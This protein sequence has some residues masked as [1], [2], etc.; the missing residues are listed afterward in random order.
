[1]NDI[2]TRLTRDHQELDAILRRL[3]ED[4]TAPE[5]DA[6]LQSTWCQFEARLLCHMEA[7]E[8][9]LLPLIEASHAGEVERLRLEH[10]RIRQLVSE[11]GVAIE[12]HAARQPA[13]DALVKLLHDHAQREDVIVYEIAGQRASAVLQNRITST[14]RAGLQRALQATIGAAIGAPRRASEHR[15]RT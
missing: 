2:K 8:N 1:M 6:P 5:C 12:L 4:A 13:I 10:V 15:V 11:L 7:E 14:L 3:A 9:Y